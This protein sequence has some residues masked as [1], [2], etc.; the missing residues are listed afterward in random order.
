MTT[1]M[2]VTIPLITMFGDDDD[3]DVDDDDDDDDISVV[4]ET[5]TVMSFFVKRDW[6]LAD[7]I[8]MKWGFKDGILLLT[9]K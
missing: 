6:T 7:S 9:T 8:W 3:D 2:T 4:M 1:T 5:W